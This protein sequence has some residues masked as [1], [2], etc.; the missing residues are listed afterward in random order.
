LAVG[1]AVDGAGNAYVTGQTNSTSFPGVAGGSLQPAYGGGINDGFV[2][3]IGTLA[4]T[5]IPTLAPQ[6]VALLALLL[7]ALGFFTLKQRR[8]LTVLL[9]LAT[10]ALP[11]VAAPVAPDYGR[12]P[13]SFDVN[14][15]FE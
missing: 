9:L 13:L 12:L 3:K 15:Y 8:V 7:A 5:T 2:T 4:I 11:A 14:G 6:G 1:I 10:A